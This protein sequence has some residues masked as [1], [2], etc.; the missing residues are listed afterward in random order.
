[1][2]CFL[3]PA[4]VAAMTGFTSA[5]AFMS[6]RAR[7]EAETLFPLPMPITTTRAFRWRADE[8]AAW[9]QRQGL[10]RPPDGSNLHLLRLA[11]SA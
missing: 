6:A 2:K 4:E 7:L 5:A 3:T 8:V 11:A 10:P 1:M 9:V